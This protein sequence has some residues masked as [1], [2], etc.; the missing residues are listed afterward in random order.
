MTTVRF[1][2]NTPAYVLAAFPYLT[3]GLLSALTKLKAEHK[4]ELILDS[5]AFT[6]WNS[7]KT[8]KLDDYCSFLDTHGD[9]FNH[10]VQLDVFGD[11][12]KTFQNLQTMIARGYDVMPVFT[13]GDTLERLEEMYSITDYIMFG[14]IVTGQ[15]NQAYV[16]WFQANNKGRKVHWLGF[17]DR[18]YISHY[19]PHSVDSSSWHFCPRMGGASLYVG[20]GRLASFDRHQ[21][22]AQQKQITPLL[23]GHGCTD[24][25]IERLK[26]GGRDE[27]KSGINSASLDLTAASHLLRSKEIFDT[28]GSKLYLAASTSFQIDSLRRALCMLKHST[29]PLTY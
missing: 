23:R 18:R 4:V 24:A 16:N 27:W 19:K 14:G 5:G 1:K 3:K 11:P 20:Q 21:F 9:L 12:E 6:A 29:Q 10:K 7:G 28:F 25:F 17:V 22:L 2:S 8:I 13:R 15:N 26:T